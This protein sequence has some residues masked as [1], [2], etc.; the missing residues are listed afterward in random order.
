MKIFLKNIFPILLMFNISIMT[1]GQNNVSIQNKSNHLFS[2][3]ILIQNNTKKIDTVNFSK[4]L[5]LKIK[6]N[7]T[8]LF[9]E[10]RS[11]IVAVIK[12]NVKIGDKILISEKEI[13]AI[14]CLMEAPEYSRELEIRIKNISEKVILAVFKGDTEKLDP[15]FQISGLIIDKDHK[16]KLWQYSNNANYEDHIYV[17]LYFRDKNG[18]LEKKSY[19]LNY[20][21]N[22]TLIVE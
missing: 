2:K 13:I 22:N 6:T 20:F 15:C 17:Y 11:N 4:I 19:S 7:Y 1:Y 18:K 3:V 9:L 5:K 8:L 10:S 12:C 21:S 16:L 14:D